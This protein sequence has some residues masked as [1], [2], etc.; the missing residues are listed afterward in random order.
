MVFVGFV[1]FVVVGLCWCDIFL[2]FFQVFGF[3]GV[4]CV[5]V[6]IVCFFVCRVFFWDVLWCVFFCCVLFVSGFVCLVECVQMSVVFFFFV[7]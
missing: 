2:F 3:Y 4:S 1:C 6:L 5:G 7:V